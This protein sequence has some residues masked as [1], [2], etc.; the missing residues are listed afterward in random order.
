MTAAMATSAREAN[1]M[2]MYAN[3]EMDLKVYPLS[4]ARWEDFELLFGKRGACGGCWCMLWRV[5]KAEFESGKGEPNKR[6]MKSIVD[7]GEPA[8]VLAY[9]DGKAIGWCAVAPREAYRR[10]AKSKSLQKVDDQP[11]WSITCLFIDKPHRRQGLSSELIRGAVEFSR[12]N[13]A[14]IVEAYP[15]TPY[16]DHVPDAF[17]WTGLPAVYEKIGFKEVLRRTKKKPIMRLYL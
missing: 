15:S 17:L 14:H 11:V 13:Q 6:S 8:G 16:S 4:R 7:A 5:E 2:L 10:L 1:Y 9:V 12:A 3:N